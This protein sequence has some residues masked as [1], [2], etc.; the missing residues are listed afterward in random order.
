MAYLIR[1]RDDL[2]KLSFLLI[3]P[4]DHCFNDRRVVGA[5]VYEAMG[6]ASLADRMS[7]CWSTR[8]ELTRTILTSHI[9]SKKANDAVYLFL[10]SAF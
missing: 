1:T 5:K 7:E 8:P 10:Q 3:L 6:N 9:A 4:F 2:W